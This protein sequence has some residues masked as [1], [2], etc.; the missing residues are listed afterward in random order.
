MAGG[1]SNNAAV[2]VKQLNDTDWEVREGFT[3][4]GQHDVFEVKIGDQT[5]FASVPR[6]FVWFLPRYG[7]YTL[8]AVL[9]DHLWRDLASNGKLD[10]IPTARSGA[11]C[12]SSM[13]RS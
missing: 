4:Q 5:D 9:H 7:A 8:A 11:R 6:V 10:Y 3:Y 12:A 1:F 2:V 13:F